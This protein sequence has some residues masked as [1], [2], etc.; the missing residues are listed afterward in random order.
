MRPIPKH[1][2][3]AVLLAMAG[4]AAVGFVSIRRDVD[5]LRV[6]SQ[7]NILWSAAQI[8]HELLRFQ[9][10]VADLSRE[11]TDEARDEA[12]ARFDILW[13][14]VAMMR[15]GR[16]GALMRQYDEG[17]ESL[18]AVHAFLERVDPVLIS[19]DATDHATLDRIMAELDEMQTLL[20]LYTLRVVR[21]DTAASAALWDR[22]QASSQTTG[23]ISLAAVLLSV[24]SLSLILREN[25]RQ[26]QLADMNRQLAE[27]AEQAS[28]AKSRFLSMMS[29]ELR[30]PLNGI[31]GP[32]ALLG[33]SHLAPT[34]E[35][36]VAQAKTCGRSMLQMLAGLL[37]YGEM[38][39]GRFR[40]N[41]EPFSATA[42]LSGIRSELAGEAGSQV[43]V[44]AGAGMPE[45]L[46]GDIDRIRQIFVHLCE[47]FLELGDPHSAE[48]WLDHDGEN[49]VGSIRF[50]DAGP[51][52]DWKLDLLMGL[53]DVAPDQ[54]SAD[55]LRPLIARGLLDASAG[56]LSFSEGAA[57][58]RVIRVA[59]PAPVLPP[60]RIRVHLETRSAALA[61]IYRAALG[62]E[63]IDFAAAGQD[64]PADFVVV[65][66][67]GSDDAPVLA[68]L[69]A[70]NPRA[71]FV[72]LGRPES[73]AFFDDV[74]ESP[75]DIGQ[76]RRSILG[77]LA[78]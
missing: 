13:S 43:R 41:A 46:S 48:L 14:R 9:I 72:S 26:R 62:S 28:L 67:P 22:I 39:D 42:L 37:D 58:E 16:V 33:Q 10:S 71:L 29:H 19:M 63:R 35:R 49:L 15:Q 75:G 24:F 20:R 32:L 7:D 38:Q 4:F 34:Q 59:I 25:R 47:Y 73:P 45:R 40:L 70:R 52:I 54:V 27:N 17:H 78:S 1:V 31:L 5:N 50:S 56:R 18:E 21:R 69:K 8:E 3:L 64:E 6:I 55:A 12:M 53:G 51:S 76:L 74:V 57:G 11:Q 44:E 68:R 2:G 23:V 77:R 60:T 65:D 66:N 30:N 61:A 36:L